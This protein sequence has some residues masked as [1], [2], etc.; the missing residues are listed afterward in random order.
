M[1]RWLGRGKLEIFEKVTPPVRVTCITRSLE[2][3]NSRPFPG[4]KETVEL[5]QDAGILPERV[6]IVCN[7]ERQPGTLTQEMDDLLGS[8]QR[9]RRVCFA[10]GVPLLV[11]PGLWEMERHEELYPELA[12]HC[13]IWMIADGLNNGRVGRPLI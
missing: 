3:N 13:D 6:I 9:A 2:K 5:L 10:Y 7:P 12:K 4:I 8:S 1:F 11:G